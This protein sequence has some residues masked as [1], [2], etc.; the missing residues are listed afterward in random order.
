MTEAQKMTAPISE[1]RVNGKP[2]GRVILA[3]FCRHP[4]GGFEASLDLGAQPT[5]AQRKTARGHLQRAW[6]KHR[7][8]KH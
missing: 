7:V 6:D 3:V 2:D 5:K 1:S 4:G 8:E